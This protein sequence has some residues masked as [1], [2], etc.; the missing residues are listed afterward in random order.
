MMDAMLRRFPALAVM[1][2]GLLIAA[3]GHAQELVVRGL[4]T[5][6]DNAP[7]AGQRVVLHRVDTTGGATIAETL[8][9]EEGRF[10]LRATA[11][12][13]TTAVLFV[14]ARYID[15]ELYIGPPFRAGDATATDQFIQVG[16]PEMSASAMM[17][18]DDGMAMPMPRRTSPTRT[19]VLIFIPLLG[20][21]GVIVYAVM[22][23]A[24]IPHDRALLIRIAE[25][26]ERMDAAPDAQRESMREERERLLA[27]LRQG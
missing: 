14:A 1:I 24:R 2:A 7:V 23:R 20:V 25:M 4:V 15:E 18:Q 9:D 13:D 21:A 27:E 26:D 16:V 19:W 12:D 17:A 6:P 10:E 3:S 11:A 22:P 5:G 8:S